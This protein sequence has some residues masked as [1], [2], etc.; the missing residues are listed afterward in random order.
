MWTTPNDPADTLGTR[1]TPSWITWRLAHRLAL[2]SSS[3]V[4]L[5]AAIAAYFLWIP[6]T[7]PLGSQVDFHSQTHKIRAL[8]SRI[9]ELEQPLASSGV[10]QQAYA[11]ASLRNTLERHLP[12]HRASYW[13]PYKSNIWLPTQ[14]A[15][16]A[17]VTIQHYGS[18]V[19]Y[20][21][22][23]YSYLYLDPIPARQA[24]RSAVTQGLAEIDDTFTY[25]L[26]RVLFRPYPPHEHPKHTTPSHD[27]YRTE[28]YYGATE[29]NYAPLLHALCHHRAFS[30]DQPRGLTTIYAL[31]ANSRN[32][33]YTKYAQALDERSTT[34]A[35]IRGSL[36]SWPPD[37]ASL[38]TLAAYVE[39]TA[40][41]EP[42]HM[43]ELSYLRAIRNTYMFTT[44]DGRGNGYQTLSPHY[45]SFRSLLYS[46]RDAIKDIMS[47][48]NSVFLP[49]RRA[50]EA[51]L[52]HAQSELISLV[53][54]LPADRDTQN[55][56]VALAELSDALIVND[57]EF[58]LFARNGWFA[59][60]PDFLATIDHVAILEAGTRTMLAIELHRADHGDYPASLAS[61]DSRLRWLVHD[62]PTT[63]R[64]FVYKRLASDPL[65]AGRQYTLYALD[66]DGIDHG[67]IP[68]TA[69]N[70]L[71]VFFYESDSS[72]F[73]SPSRNRSVLGVGANFVFNLP[74]DWL[75]TEFRPATSA[76]PPTTTQ[77]GSDPPAEAPGTAP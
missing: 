74:L 21:E 17:N 20:A 12:F 39:E 30:L 64:P 4:A 59:G 32:T 22:H 75:P 63:G 33:A 9:H 24:L 65:N 54:K 34:L 45:A 40:L 8:D 38:R 60:L 51:K 10:S 15:R 70:S 57:A 48:Y 23:G 41:P 62:D 72:G 27:T 55:A 5:L 31:L 11:F 26:H 53:S 44:D 1:R 42:A 71:Q 61:I 13:Y 77:T 73:F 19:Y 18:G 2:V 67:G 3:S 25:I 76:E 43:I 29:D 6:M 37:A 16:L 56:A 58:R 50:L 66:S 7:Q 68:F 46:D 14:Y 36:A 49:R 52:T 35:L 28:T 69:D 47:R